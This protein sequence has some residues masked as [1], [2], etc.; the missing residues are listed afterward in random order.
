MADADA[1][2]KL[3]KPKAIQAFEKRFA[4]EADHWGDVFFLRVADSWEDFFRTAFCFVN[5]SSLKK[6][7]LTKVKD[8]PISFDG[9]T[10]T[11]NLLFKN[12]W[13]SE[14]VLV[15][16]K[17]KT[18]PVAGCLITDLSDGIYLLS[19]FGSDSRLD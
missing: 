5:D 6:E 8:L 16:G 1:D 9:V 18:S 13:G 19:W 2:G 7:S 17:L 15:Q 12:I 10:L 11:G 14:C 4:T 3:V